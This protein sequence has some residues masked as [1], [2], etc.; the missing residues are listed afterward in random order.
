MEA[1]DAVMITKL[2]HAPLPSEDWSLL[3][4]RRKVQLV[5]MAE[6]VEFW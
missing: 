2:Q 5:C 6:T 4:E 1:T 3:V